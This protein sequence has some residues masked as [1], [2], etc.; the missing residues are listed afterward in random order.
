MC[1]QWCLGMLELYDRRFKLKQKRNGSRSISSTQHNNSTFLYRNSRR[2]PARNLNFGKIGRNNASLF[3]NQKFAYNF[4]HSIV[5]AIPAAK[6]N[7]TLRLAYH[8]P[9]IFN[10]TSDGRT[11]MIFQ[12]KPQFCTS[13]EC[14][15]ISLV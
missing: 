12:S 4:K 9:E 8:R 3:P 7:S 11:R 14:K 5:S 2:F 15:R 13:L 10:E 6:L 1:R